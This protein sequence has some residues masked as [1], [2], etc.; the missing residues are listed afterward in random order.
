M[1]LIDA[2]ALKELTTKRNS[3]WNKI[4]DSNGRGLDEIID[5][6][7]TIE[8]EHW[9]PVPDRLPK[10]EE[11]VLI[12]DTDGYLYIGF[13]TSNIDFNL[14]PLWIYDEHMLHREDEVS[15]W[16]PLPKPYVKMK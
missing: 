9:N 3:I 1:I 6:L 12:C 8:T 10:Y 2:D 15:A 14:R 7:P 11:N 13:L 5:S 4:T 16:Q